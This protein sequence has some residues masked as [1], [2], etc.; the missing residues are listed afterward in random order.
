MHGKKEFIGFIVQQD[1]KTKLDV[2]DALIESLSPGDHEMLIHKELE[3]LSPIGLERARAKLA[4]LD[5]DLPFSEPFNPCEDCDG[6]CRCEAKCEKKDT[7]KVP[8][9]SN[10]TDYIKIGDKV[11][12][13]KGGDYG[14][15][16][17]V[18]STPYGSLVGD[19]HGNIYYMDCVEVCE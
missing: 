12:V 6:D 8:E 19:E 10:Q 4:E 11:R 3:W 9:E 17:I 15:S 18:D 1:V 5:F 16:F 13:R 7:A 2:I 14:Y